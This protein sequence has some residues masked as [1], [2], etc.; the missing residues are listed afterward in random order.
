MN[1]LFLG[2]IPSPIVDILFENGCKIFAQESPISMEFLEENA[3]EFALSYRYRHLIKRSAIQYL[4]GRIVNLHISLLPW[5]RGAD[6]NLWSF[7]ED[8]PKGVTIHYVDE[9]LDTGEILVQKDVN[10]YMNDTLRSTYSRL[11]ATI[12]DLFRIHWPDIISGRLKSYPQIGSGSFHRIKDKEP[13]IC[14]LKNGW[15]TPVSDLIGRAK[16][17]GM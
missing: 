2:K 7:L 4:N 13:F 5:N 17:A 12:E 8:T 3:F 9:G 6:P 10:Y 1:V 16:Y 14:L 11:S 15:D